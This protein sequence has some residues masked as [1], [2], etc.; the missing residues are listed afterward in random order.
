MCELNKCLE[1]LDMEGTPIRTALVG[2]GSMGSPLVAQIQQAP[3]MEIDIVVD[4]KLE[5]A[6][7]ALTEYAGIDQSRIAVC[8]SIAETEKALK[9]GKKVCSSNLEVAWGTKSIDVVCEATGY[10]AAYANISLN[11][12]RNKKHVVT[13][14]VEGDVCIGH[15]LK[16][17]ADN[18]GV[19]YTGIYGDEPGSAMLLYYEAVSLGFKVVAMG[20]SEMGGGNI[21]WNKETIKKPLRDTGR[22]KIQ[23]N[24]AM[25]ASF[26]D[27]SKT[28]EECCMMANATGLRPDVRGMHGPYVSYEDFTLEVPRLMQ[29]KKDGGILDHIGVVE[30]IKPPGDAPVGIGPNFIWQFVVVGPTTPY[31]K[32]A[33]NRGMKEGVNN[34]VFYSCY[35]LISVQAPITI[36]EAMID[37]RAVIAPQGNKRAADVITMA[38]KDL[39]VGEIIDEIGG[40]CT[41]GRIEV[42]SISRKEKS[43]PFA[44]A[45]GAKVK[46]PVPKGGFLTYDDVEFQGDPSL[47]FQLR[48]LQDQLFG[49]LH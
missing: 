19:I 34:R 22:D 30:R 21:E 36:A 32:R 4:L 47:I 29:L 25:Y 8:D 14:N 43:L 37:H 3:G 12:L 35:H 41:T 44:L 48:K 15:I 45:A 49:D 11:A 7:R 20:R 38:K 23:F 26:C 28:N 17:F 10:P 2:A 24:T 27:G 18:A 9:S 16:M 40:F 6:M 39:E 33:M 13:L 42:A 31:Q 1:K 5:N 46:R